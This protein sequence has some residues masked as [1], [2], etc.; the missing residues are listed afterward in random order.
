MIWNMNVMVHFL[1]EFEVSLLG[2]CC[3]FKNVFPIVDSIYYCRCC[4]GVTS[5]QYHV[6]PTHG[7]GV[8]ESCLGPLTGESGGHQKALVPLLCSFVFV[9]SWWIVILLSPVSLTLE[10]GKGRCYVK[11]LSVMLMQRWQKIPITINSVVKNQLTNKQV[12]SQC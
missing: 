12:G 10:E 1:H 3:N 9:A 8:L 4:G 5:R 7:L 6:A 2:H 11:W